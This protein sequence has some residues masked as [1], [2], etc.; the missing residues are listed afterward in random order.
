MAKSKEQ[1]ASIW[2]NWEAGGW[3]SLA[4]EI[5]QLEEKIEKLELVI[6]C[7]SA[8]MTDVY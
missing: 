4:D 6:E 1:S 3:E 2:D 7:N 8:L 5:A